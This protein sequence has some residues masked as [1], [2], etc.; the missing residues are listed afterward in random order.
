[1]CFL[2]PGLVSQETAISG[3]FQQKNIGFK[4]SR[5]YKLQTL[6]SSDSN[7]VCS[8]FSSRSPEPQV[9]RSSFRSEERR[10]KSVRLEDLRGG[11][12]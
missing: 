9:L 8:P 11:V 3:S 10:G 2:G 1:M 5:K 4:N 7:N 12:L 6:C